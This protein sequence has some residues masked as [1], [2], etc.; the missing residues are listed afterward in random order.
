MIRF[1]DC[2]MRFIACATRGVLVGIVVGGAFRVAAQHVHLAVGAEAAE[3]GS[4]L[5]FSNGWLYDTN[6]WGGLYPA[7]VYMNDGDPLYPG[8][9]QTDVTFIALPATI[10]TGGPTPYSA[11][12]GAYI[13]MKLI[14]L[15]GP[16]GGEFSMW[17]ENEDATQTAKKFTMPVGTTYSTNQFN[18]SEGITNPE[19]DPFG[20]VHGRR[21][22]AN[23]PGLYTLGVQLIDTS[24]A[25]P[26]GGSVHRPSDTNYFYFQ[27]GLV[28][29][30]HVRSNNT[31]TAWFGTRA[32]KNYHLETSPMPDGTNWVKVGAVP[33]ASHSDIHFLT[34]TNAT[35]TSS[36]YRIRE[37]PQ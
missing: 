10:W 36:F 9:F 32:F 13:E 17:E 12:L 3:P 33:W 29:N 4:K 11:E 25:G 14:S 2:V 35:S 27:A 37:L 23:K 1:R 21:F 7:C 28:I 34:D 26:G 24:T 31:F 16:P 8:L 15:Q 20:H 5:F 18:L 6:S 22:T 19:P 30:A